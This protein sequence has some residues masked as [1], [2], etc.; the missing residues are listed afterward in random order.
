MPFS[1]EGGS[2]KYWQRMYASAV[3]IAQSLQRHG[4]DPSECD[5]FTTSE[6]HY[7]CTSNGVFS[8]DEDVVFKISVLML[9]ERHDW[10]YGDSN[11]TKGPN[12]NA[13]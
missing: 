5:M 7:I 2:A 11:K 13:K 1:P 10:S 12:D 8:F 6:I 4:V 9:Q 3:V